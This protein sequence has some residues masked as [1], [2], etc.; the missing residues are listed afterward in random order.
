MI[1][2]SVNC[3]ICSACI[4]G[5][6]C[7]FKVFKLYNYAQIIKIKKLK[8]NLHSTMEKKISSL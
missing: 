2:S 3:K 1:I 5:S 6:R 8:P 7:T 4:N